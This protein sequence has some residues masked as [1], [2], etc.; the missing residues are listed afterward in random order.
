MSEHRSLAAHI[1]TQYGSLPGVEAVVLAGSQSSGMADP[2]SDIDLYV[3]SRAPLSPTSRMQIATGRAHHVE[4][5]NQFWERG[6]E[7]IE[8]ESGTRV[9]IMLR[10]VTWIEGQLN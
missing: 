8:R 1:A 6:D 10:D 5:D 3:Y 7:W 4:I 2:D 9:D